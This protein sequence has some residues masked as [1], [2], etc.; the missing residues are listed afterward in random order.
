MITGQ[1]ITHEVE[2]SIEVKMVIEDKYRLR[3]KM[4]YVAYTMYARWTRTV[5]IIAVLRWYF[6]MN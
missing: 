2:E 1:C 4:T 6:D 3:T 5:L